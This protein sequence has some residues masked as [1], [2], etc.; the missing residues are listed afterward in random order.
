MRYIIGLIVLYLVFMVAGGATIG[1]TA[2]K[3]LSDR[4]ASIE[5]SIE[6]AAQ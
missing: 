6:L 4:A 5:A 3:L 2:Y 1:A